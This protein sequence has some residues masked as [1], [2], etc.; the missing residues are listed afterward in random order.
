MAMR[1]FI[2]GL[3]IAILVAIFALQNSEPLRIHLFLWSFPRISEA[4]VILG[5][6][7]FG[8]VF[9]ALLVLREHRQKSRAIKKSPP[10]AGAPS[11]EPVHPPSDKT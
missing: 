6:V 5:S 2:I 3:V 10:V 7:L 1:Q 4:L 8:A 11:D 9:G